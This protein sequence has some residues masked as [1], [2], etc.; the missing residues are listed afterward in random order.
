ML[1]AKMKEEEEK[2]T[3]DL[4]PSLTW[5]RKILSEKNDIYLVFRLLSEI[6]SVLVDTC[7]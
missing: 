1:F 5:Q 3:E 7:K 6:V 2:K 4:P